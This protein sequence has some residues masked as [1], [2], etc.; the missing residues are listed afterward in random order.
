MRRALSSHPST[1]TDSIFPLAD[2]YA[3][4]APARSPRRL[5]AADLKLTFSSC[6]SSSRRPRRQ[7]RL[8]RVRP[9]LS[10][11]RPSQVLELTGALAGGPVPTRATRASSTGTTTSSRCSRATSRSCSITSTPTPAYVLSLSLPSRRRAAGRRAH[12]SSSTSSSRRSRSRTTRPL[13]V[14]PSFPLLL[15]LPLAPS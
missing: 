3:Y 13:W 10:S 6:L 7:V 4:C 1:L 8:H 11:A 15:P 2:N 9:S 14:R 5:A 12:S